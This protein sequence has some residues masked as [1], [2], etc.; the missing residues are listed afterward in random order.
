MRTVLIGMG[1]IGGT[2]ATMAYEGGYKIDVV[3]VGEERV[4]MLREEGFTLTGAKGNHKVKMNAFNGVDSLEGEY[5]VCII[6]TKYQQMPEIARQMLPHLKE[7]SLVVC[8]QNGIQVKALAEVVGEDRAVG[9]M[10]GFGATGLGVNKVEMSSLGEFYIGMLGGRRPEKLNYIKELLSACLPTEITDDIEGRLYSKLIINSCINSLA[11]I[12]GKPLGQLVDDKTAC[13]IFLEIT[14]E[15]M[16]TAKKMGIK[17][18]KYGKLLEY[19]LLMLMD[20]PVYN[21]ICELVVKAVSKAKYKDVKPS[22]LQ[23]LENG[24]KTEIDIMNGLIS[25]FG[26]EYGVPTPVNDRLTE[27]IKEIERGERKICLENLDEFRKK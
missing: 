4:R 19:R 26:K 17:V 15:G 8:M 13:N 2:V 14:R 20:N 21:G 23:S 7:D 22:T 24:Q 12:T 11:G 1:C 9:I 6:A 25:K 5:D 16:R 18:P 3:D 27:M 10:I